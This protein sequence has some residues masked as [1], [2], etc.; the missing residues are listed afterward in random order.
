MEKEDS[1]T[2]RAT[3]LMES[4][5]DKTGEAIDT[6]ASSTGLDVKRTT[7][8]L[9]SE[10]LVIPIIEQSFYRDKKLYGDNNDREAT[11]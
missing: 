9:N 10:P 8:Q 6:L 4:M 1:I 3:D 11:S 2:A 5:K 7:L